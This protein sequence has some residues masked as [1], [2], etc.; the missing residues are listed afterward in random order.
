MTTDAIATLATQQLMELSLRA[1]GARYISGDAVADAARSAAGKATA[2]QQ[3]AAGLTWRGRGW[4]G[5][6][7]IKAAVAALHQSLVQQE[8][9]AG[10]GRIVDL[11]KTRSEWADT[12]AARAIGLPVSCRH[13]VIGKG[14]VDP[15]GGEAIQDD[16]GA[17]VSPSNLWQ[18]IDGMARESSAS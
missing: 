17:W 18:W 1:G 16:N 14:N 10:L 11:Y 9:A 4:I 12:A 3:Q 8:D 5:L 2:A 7:P 15:W 13:P 6:D